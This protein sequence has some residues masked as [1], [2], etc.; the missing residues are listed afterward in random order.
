MERFDV[1]VVGG[2][3]IG[4][5]IAWR[6]A[7]LR[8]RVALFEPNAMHGASYAAAGMLAPVAEA[9]F[10]EEAL[11][12]LNLAARDAW[13]GFAADLEQASATSLG[14]QQ[15]G[16]L[17]IAYDRGDRDALARVH[18]YHGELG[19]PSSW[20]SPSECRRLEPALAP[21]VH[22]GVL[23][24]AD[25]RVDNRHL[26][27]AL[28][29]A[30]VAAGV[31]MIAER[32]DEV[33]VDHGRVAGAG[34]GG[35]L[36]DAPV[37]VLSTGAERGHIAGLDETLLP[38]VRPVKGQIARLRMTSGDP[39]LTRTVDAIVEGRHVYLVPRG[40]GRIVAGA[41]VEERGSDLTVTAGACADIL[42]DALSVVPA[43]DEAEFVELI[44]RHRPGT[45]D[46]APIMG[47][48]PLEGLLVAT[49]HYRN[50]ILLAPVTAD[51]MTHLI[52]EGALPAYAAP[53]SPA[54]FVSPL[55]A[56]GA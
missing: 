26:L 8:H 43:L 52:I 17:L 48:T 18:A 5:S 56:S 54:R 29:A 40:D 24:E 39:L 44:A 33:R 6:L 20:C 3:V 25:G 19:L 28:H 14:F 38:P 21:G 55:A 31:T 49:G 50:G 27:V 12:A 32:V 4:A 53:F 10:G 41:T 47:P 13:P 2:G 16:T 51:A 36:V 15:E 37:V 34:A 9:A 11:L 46:N 22:A 45:P 23:I 1:V 35:H 30:G 7:R 42:R